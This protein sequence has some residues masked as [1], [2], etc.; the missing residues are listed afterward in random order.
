MSQDRRRRCRSHQRAF[1]DC[2]RLSLSQILAWADSHYARTGRWPQVYTGPVGDG[3]PG[4]RWRRIDNA[5]RYGLRGLPGGSSLTQ[6]LSQ[7]R[8]VRNTQKLP[9]L[10]EGQILA[11][12]L[13]QYRRTGTWPTRYSGLVHGTGEVWSNLDAALRKGSRELPGNSSLA[14]LLAERLGVRT[15]VN[16]PA[17]S[18]ERILAWADAHYRQTGLWPKRGSGSITGAPGESW[19]AVDLA[20]QKGLRGLPGR[21]SLPQLLAEYR[22]ARNRAALHRQGNL[23]LQRATGSTGTVAPQ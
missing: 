6:L 10:T 2:A 12:A 22:G 5:L 13:A 7:Y 21:S 19:H 1:R 3:L 11:W 15:R 16:V 8:G 17:L 4:E 18:A 23:S 20:L 9:P 14:K